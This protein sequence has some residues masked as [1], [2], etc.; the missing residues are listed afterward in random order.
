MTYESLISLHLCGCGRSDFRTVLVSAQDYPKAEIF[1]GYSYLHV[2]TH[3][4]SSNSLVNE[5]NI[6]ARGTCPLT[7][8]VNPGFNGWAAAGQFDYQFVSSLGN[9]HQ[10]DFRFSSGIVFGFRG[11]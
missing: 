11:K 1:G 2:D 4:I 6:L 3:G 10:N 8:G 7:F 9:G 5:C